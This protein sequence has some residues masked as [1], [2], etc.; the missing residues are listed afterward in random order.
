[1]KCIEIEII[2][3]RGCILAVGATNDNYNPL[4]LDVIKTGVSDK[5]RVTLPVFN[6][7][8]TAECFDKELLM[9]GE[10]VTLAPP[11][12]MFSGRAGDP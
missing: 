7:V 4:K 2:D 12:G 11:S 3:S 6:H 9:H 1:M 10:T 5:M 8:K